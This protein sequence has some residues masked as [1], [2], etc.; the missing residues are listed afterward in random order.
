MTRK[1]SA[2]QLAILANVDAGRRPFHG[3]PSGRSAAGGWDASYRSL[4]RRGLLGGEP[5]VATTLTDAGFV[6][7]RTGRV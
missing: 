4:I 1:L 3:M 5:Y 6:G 7:L 2:T